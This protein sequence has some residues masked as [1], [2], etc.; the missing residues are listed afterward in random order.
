MTES[1]AE[2][3]IISPHFDDEIIGLY[4]VISDQK[5]KPII[6][7]MQNDEE[8]KQEAL[9]IRAE[10]NN[11]QIQ[12]FQNSIPS[13][14]LNPKNTLYFPDPVY[15]FHPDHR[16]WGIQGESLF[17]QGLNVVFYSIN[18]QAPYIHTVEESN[19]KRDLLNKIYPSQSDLWKYQHKYFIWEGRYKFLM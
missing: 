16:Y 12:L 14:L 15:E 13:F 6:I 3:V 1:R 17:R 18:M 8:R 7:Y 4:E 19:K 5:N 9:K 11:I 2:T 10:L